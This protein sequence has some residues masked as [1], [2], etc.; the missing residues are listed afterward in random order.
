MSATRVLN[1]K[2]VRIRWQEPE[3]LSLLQSRLQRHRAKNE[4]S[5]YLERQS[6]FAKV[7][8]DPDRFPDPRVFNTALVYEVAVLRTDA[9]RFLLEVPRSHPSRTQAYRLSWPTRPP[10]ILRAP[11]PRVT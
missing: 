4:K 6:G 8:V 2:D 10:P 1:G 11:P 7:K 9:W 3:E 5:P